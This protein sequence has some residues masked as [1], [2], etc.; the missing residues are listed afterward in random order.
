[1][2]ASDRP[3]DLETLASALGS[4]IATA[5]P[6]PWGDSQATWRLQ[7]RDGRNLVVRRYPRGSAGR[8]ERVAAAMRAAAERG[9]PVPAAQVVST[10]AATW[11]IADEIEGSVGA[12][13]LDT[14][15]RA[16]T[17]AASMGRLRRQ[18]TTVEPSA[19][20]MPGPA[21]P[22]H[23]PVP[24]EPWLGNILGASA[25]VIARRRTAPVFVHG[26]FAPINVIVDEDGAIRALLDFD[27]ARSG[28]PLEDVAWWGWVVRHHHPAVWHV[29]W[30]AF[31][32]AAGIDPEADGP[33]IRALTLRE[34]GHRAA[35][36]PSAAGA[37]RWTA[38]LAVASEW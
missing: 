11:L 15:D 20:A 32:D 38:R 31:L 14:P 7:I 30:A 3:S 29:A 27:Y 2:S 10:V 25:A 19:V 12:A 37:E 6:V 22:R 17:L 13:W 5:S 23:P 26:D 9:V 18:L 28:D 34:L 16:R 8:A 36:S 21:E 35:A 1:M 4:A 33:A 24:P